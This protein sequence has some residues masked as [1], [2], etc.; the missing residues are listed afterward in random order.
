MALVLAAGL[1]PAADLFRDDFSRY[2]SGWLT[3][4]V[5]RLN[6]AIQEYHYLPHRG[7]PLEPWENALCHWDA[8]VAGQEDGRVPGAGAGNDRCGRPTAVRHR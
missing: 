6:A 7:V 1:L 5:G 2:P 8:W 3:A 4:P